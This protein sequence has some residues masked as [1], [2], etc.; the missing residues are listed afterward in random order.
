MGVGGFYTTAAGLGKGIWPGSLRRES[1]GTPKTCRATNHPASKPILRAWFN[2]LNRILGSANPSLYH[3]SSQASKVA[4]RSA[5]S[6]AWAV[7]RL[8]AL[9][10]LTFVSFYLAKSFANL[11]S[12]NALFF[13]TAVATFFSTV[14]AAFIFSLAVSTAVSHA[15]LSQSVSSARSFARSPKMW[16]SWA[17]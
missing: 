12:A 15:S 8:I 10:S 3:F 5:S 13:Y 1:S 2:R 9:A 4:L 6:S 11:F 16:A 17:A 14:S 7:F